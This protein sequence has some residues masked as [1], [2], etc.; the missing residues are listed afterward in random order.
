MHS[1]RAS[2]QPV[3]VSVLFIAVPTNTENFK[4]LLRLFCFKY[5]WK[6]H[7]FVYIAR[8]ELQYAFNSCRSTV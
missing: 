3:L 6:R 8:H 5:H 2:S 4:I 7:I 1:L